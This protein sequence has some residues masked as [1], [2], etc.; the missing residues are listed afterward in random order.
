MRGRFHE[1]VRQGLIR[2]GWTITADPLLVA[3][4]GLEM[5]VDLGAEKLLAA[6]KE[7]R[8]IAV[9]IKTFLGP[10]IISDFHVALG[11]FLNYRLALE[12]REP[13]RILYLAVPS[14][15]Y[16]TFGRYPFYGLAIERHSVPLVVYEP[17]SERYF[18]GYRR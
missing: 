6:R 15:T 12:S 18:N 13:E 11:Q 7:N 10:S 14:Q 1:A 4:G 16:N 3:F 9:E 8:E 2:D 5:Q 17:E